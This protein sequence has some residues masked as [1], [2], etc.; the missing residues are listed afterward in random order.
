MASQK[1]D[2]TRSCELMKKPFFLS[3][4]HKNGEI[5]QINQTISTE[6]ISKKKYCFTDSTFNKIGEWLAIVD[7]LGNVFIFDLASELYWNLPKVGEC[8]FIKF[9]DFV[10]NELLVGLND[11]DIY[12]IHSE[13]GMVQGCLSGHSQ[14]VRHV[15]FASSVPYCLTATNIDAVVWDLQLNV[16]LQKLNLQC[17]TAIKIIK[18]MPATNNILGCFEDD[19]IHIWK[20]ESLKHLNKFVLDELEVSDIQSIAFTRSGRAMVIINGNGD[21][22]VF[23]LDLETIQKTIF[24]PNVC[25]DVSYIDFLPQIFDGGANKILAVQSTRCILLFNIETLEIA[26]TFDIEDRLIKIECSPHG[27]YISCILQDGNVKI[28]STDILQK[29][30]KQ[31][32]D[33][34]KKDAISTTKYDDKIKTIN[35]TQQD[36]NSIQ[37]EMNKILNIEKLLPL[38][39]QFGEYPEKYRRLIWKNLLQLPGNQVAYETLERKGIHSEYNS[40]EEKYPLKNKTLLRNLLRILS[41]LSHWTPFFSQ[42]KY[43]PVFVLPFLKVFKYDRLVCFEIIASIIVNWCQLWFEY[44]PLPPVKLLSIVEDVLF[45]HDSE[46]S[47]HLTRHK[48]TPD[49]YAWPLLETAF[50]EVCWF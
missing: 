39:K 17:S 47:S 34:H 30:I 21:M 19:T 25:A 10:V 35:K 9:N 22:A 26:N 49:V 23:S 8:S 31:T 13:T 48:I 46:L 2:K 3:K 5:I 6:Y 41:C 15:S 14:P 43:M 20:S 45:E 38:L 24:I 36:L 50:S 27:K 44:F 28:L 16:Q 32:I 40:L 33:S 29:T 18:F 7:L 4:S 12:I 37:S 1:N 42:V 11:G